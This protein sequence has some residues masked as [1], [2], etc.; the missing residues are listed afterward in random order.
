MF[1]RRRPIM[2]RRRWWPRRFYYRRGCLPGCFTFLL[3]GL[4][5]LGLALAIVI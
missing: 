3:L 1:F 2:F 5:L 4:L